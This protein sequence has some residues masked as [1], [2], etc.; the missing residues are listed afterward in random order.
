MKE[1]LTPIKMP[2]AETG[3][4]KGHTRIELTTVAT[5][6]KKIIEHE[7]VFQSAVLSRYLRSLGA[8]NNS[9]YANAT[10][11][12]RK[13][14]RNLCGGI[15]LFRDEIQ[16]PAE[17]MPAGNQMVANGS[18]GVSNAATPAELG[19]YNAIESSTAGNTSISFV[20][21]WGTSQGNGTISCVCLTSEV[22][23]LIGYGNPS[24]GI[25]ASPIDIAANQNSAQDLGG[26]PYKNMLYSFT[27]NGTDKSV[28]V[29]RVK[30]GIDNASI[31][32]DQ[33]TES[34][35]LT[36]TSTIPGNGVIVNYSGG[37]KFKLIPFQEQSWDGV[38]P[39][40]GTFKV[41]IFDAEEDTL[42]EETVS[43]N[44]QNSVW[45]FGYNESQNFAAAAEGKI[46]LPT[47]LTSTTYG[48][49]LVIL[50]ESGGAAD[51]LP[52]TINASIGRGG[53]AAI[54]P[55][56]LYIRDNITRGFYI[57]DTVSKTIYPTNGAMQYG[58]SAAVRAYNDQVDALCTDLTQGGE[59]FK[60][61]LYLATINNLDNAVT[62]DSTQT[63][64]VIYTLTEASA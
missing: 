17:Y 44:S 10:W 61:P 22:G 34:M 57:Y 42:T 14:W 29:T 47:A 3:K 32:D 5:G 63:M 28:T 13:L 51:I 39:P 24:G 4:V 21:D 53:Y 30:K 45:L 59:L 31:F 7:N 58:T 27:R 8:Y 25:Y 18:F 36:Y 12:S 11:A 38:I 33:K 15:L 43:N 20:Y 54:A 56:L 26:L 64:K 48:L 2:Q 41:L 1:I 52:N 46:L 49:P 37:G 16:A 35:T 19:S 55:G 60:N 40:A 23:G 9:P 6:K 50:D 62:K